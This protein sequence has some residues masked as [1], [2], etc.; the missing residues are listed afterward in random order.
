MKYTK[1]PDS[2]L[3]Y[4][5]DWSAWLPTGDTIVASTFTVTPAATD[6]VVVD[7]SSFNDTTTT[8]WLSG[9]ANKASYTVTNHITTSQGRQDDRSMVIQMKEL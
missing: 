2:V 5:V 8:V 7:D 4:S 6:A 1:D 9:G 3:D